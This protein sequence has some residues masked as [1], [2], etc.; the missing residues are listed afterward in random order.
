MSP[1]K[2]TKFQLEINSKQILMLHLKD[3][4]EN[5]CSARLPVK[6]DEVEKNISL[7]LKPAFFTSFLYHLTHVIIGF[8][9]T[10]F[11]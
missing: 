3:L 1:F 9:F 11:F 2:Y 7:Y 6:L 8:L 5:L 4:K 10:V